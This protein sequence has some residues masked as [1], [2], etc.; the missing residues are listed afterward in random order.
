MVVMFST[1]VTYVFDMVVMFSTVIMSLH[2]YIIPLYFI[3]TKKQHTLHNV[4]TSGLKTT[5]LKQTT[6]KL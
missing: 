1:L 6:H 3:N 5:A 4:L 2:Q